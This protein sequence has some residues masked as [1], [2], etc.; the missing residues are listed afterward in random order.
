M[1]SETEVS[2]KKPVI[3]P[4]YIPERMT[5]DKYL[6]ILCIDFKKVLHKEIQTCAKPEWGK[7]LPVTAKMFL[8]RKGFPVALRGE[9]EGALAELR[10]YLVEIGKQY[11]EY[12]FNREE[13]SRQNQAR[14]QEEAA[15]AAKD[16]RDQA[17]KLGLG[18]EQLRDQAGETPEDFYRRMGMRLK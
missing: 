11:I 7:T 10:D 13:E 9:P 17:D 14:R 18:D 12:G 1:T 4:K 3:D 5:M 2:I 8:N 6:E 15:Q 16:Q